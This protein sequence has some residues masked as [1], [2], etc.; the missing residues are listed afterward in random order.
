MNICH[1]RKV[2]FVKID[3]DGVVVAVLFDFVYSSAGLSLFLTLFI[4]VCL[5]SETRPEATSNS[6]LT[7]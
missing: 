2:F 6:M 4:H 5:F 7:D 1:R 3:H